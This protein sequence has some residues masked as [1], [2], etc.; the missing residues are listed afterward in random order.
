M[1]M[2]KGQR[3][4][5]KGLLGRRVEAYVLHDT[6]ALVVCKTDKGKVERVKPSRLLT[7]FKPHRKRQ[8]VLSYGADQEYKTWMDMIKATVT[9]DFDMFLVE[10]IWVTLNRFVFTNQLTMPRFQRADT[11]LSGHFSSKNGL[12][13]VLGK[14]PFKMRGITETMAHEMCHQFQHEKMG[15]T[16]HTDEEWHG[17]D[18]ERLR[19]LAA[20]KLGIPVRRR[21]KLEAETVDMD[22]RP[23]PSDKTLYYAFIVKNGRMEGLCL[24]DLQA[25]RE[26]VVDLRNNAMSFVVYEAKDAAIERFVHV[27]SD[28]YDWLFTFVPTHVFKYAQQNFRTLISSEN[29]A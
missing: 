25:V 6:G 5:I 20:F 11:R 29:K 13:I 12:E 26:L 14:I 15:Y 24:A 3:V 9:L 4:Q 2:T 1:H 17:A 21:H 8:L 22:L 28:P 27:H 16:E 10:S 19:K 18:F 7:S 23:T